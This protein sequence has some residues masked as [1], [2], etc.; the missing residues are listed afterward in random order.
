MPE[1]NL[2]DLYPGASFGVLDFDNQPKAIWHGMA[3]AFRPVQVLLT[4]EELDFASIRSTL[5]ES[6]LPVRRRLMRK[7]RHLSPW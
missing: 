6:R 2:R 5:A 3:R 4:D 1:W 7:L